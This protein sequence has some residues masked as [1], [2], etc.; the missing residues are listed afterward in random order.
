ML[1]KASF[2]KIAIATCALLVILILYVFPKDDTKK[3]QTE[4]KYINTTKSDIFLIDE[5]NYVAMTNIP[6]SSKGTIN[7]AKKILQTLVIGSKQSEYIPNGFTAIIPKN[8]KINSIDF[9]N[10]L[11]KVDFSKELLNVDQ[12]NEEKMIE[13]IV[14]S[15]TSIK[16]VKKVMIFVNGEILYQMPNSKKTL[17]ETFD[18]SYGINKVYDLNTISNSTKTI[19]Y[20]ISKYDDTYYYVPITKIN[21]D[22]SN[23]VE[24][25]INEL[26]NNP[27]YQTNL[28]SYLKA[29]AE[30]QDYEIKENSIS[31]SFNQNLL[32]SLDDK[33][34][35]EEV[36]YTISLSIK[37]NFDI[38][39]VIFKVNDEEIDKLVLK[40]VE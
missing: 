38:N 13:S 36:K 30:L 12:N 18:R 35:S 26:K 9:K 32:D 37:D 23:K 15:L 2:R 3:Y 28:M 29:N 20:Y 7:K 21:N 22:P 19:V 34:I 16:D 24:I 5:N 39:E 1:K 4:T 6:I 11:I 17:P 33:S 25:I 31:L 14:Y 27:I 10:N 40:T 8:T